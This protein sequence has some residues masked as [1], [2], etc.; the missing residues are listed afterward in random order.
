[1]C[2]RDRELI[3]E[4]IDE[5]KIRSSDRELYITTYSVSDRRLLTVDV[6]EAPEGEIGDMLL[7]SA[8]FPAFK[9][10]KLNGTRY[11]DC[12][13]YTSHSGSLVKKSTKES[14]RQ[15]MCLY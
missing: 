4:T 7:A 14:C 3:E 1:M 6:K 15:I 10:E 13:L 5:E 12:L 11:M 9:N 8:Y 2:I